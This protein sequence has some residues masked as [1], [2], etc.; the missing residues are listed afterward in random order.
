MKSETNVSRR[1]FIKVAAAA[2]ALAAGSAALWQ[3]GGLHALRERALRQ[4]PG[5]FYVERLRQIVSADTGRTRAAIPQRM[6]VFRRTVW[7]S[8]STRQS[9]IN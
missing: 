6:R 8:F 1:T 7:R 2:G 3:F 9:F 4:F 5:I